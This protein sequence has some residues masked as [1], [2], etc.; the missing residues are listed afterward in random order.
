MSKSGPPASEHDGESL[1]AGPANDVVAAPAPEAARRLMRMATLAAVSVACVLVATKFV[2]WVLTDSVS[3]MSTL[4][5]S[6]LDVAASVVNLV[7]VRHALEPA[8]REHRFGHGKAESLAGLA[9]AAFVAGSG[10]FL[11]LEA[12]ER[13][14]NPQEIVRTEIGYIVMVFSIVLTLALVTF[15]SFVVRR[16]GSIAIGA[17]SAHYRMDILVNAG[18]MVSLFVVAHIGWLWFDPAMAILIAAYILYGAWQIA[19]TALQVLMDHE[20]SDETRR[21]IRHIALSHPDVRNVHDLRTRTSGQHVFMQMHLEMDGS[22]SLYR[23]HEI[24]DEVEA[25]VMAAF[26]HAEVMIHQDPEGIGEEIAVFR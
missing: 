24:A 2:A 1:A 3:L 4:I 16:T 14:F 5:D 19:E 15:Q 11:L 26:P 13:L 6:L 25:D 8:D 20:L 23:A 9:Q 7:A 17:D 12:G 21:A 18:V 10:V 22:I